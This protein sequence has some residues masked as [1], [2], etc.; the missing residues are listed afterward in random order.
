MT[1]D[2]PYF[3]HNTKNYQKIFFDIP[4][5]INFLLTSHAQTNDTL[6]S[7]GVYDQIMKEILLIIFILNLFNVEIHFHK[8]VNF[9]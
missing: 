7:R 2:L 3:K 8:S 6:L 1:L 4:I 5:D 9:M